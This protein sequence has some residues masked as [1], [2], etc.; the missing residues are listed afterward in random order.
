MLEYMLEKYAAEMPFWISGY[1]YNYIV[2]FELS[3]ALTDGFF[4]WV[5]LSGIPKKLIDYDRYG[6]V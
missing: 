4:Q 3:N 1:I 2:C 5:S 6:R